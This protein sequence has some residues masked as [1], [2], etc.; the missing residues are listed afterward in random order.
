[1]SRFYRYSPWAAEQYG[2]EDRPEELIVDCPEIALDGTQYA[3][4][5]GD[6]LVVLTSGHT[7]SSGVWLAATL[8][9]AAGATLIGEPTGDI[10]DGI[11]NPVFL[12]LPHSG[13]RVAISS[14]DFHL[15]DHVEMDRASP[16]RPDIYVEA[17]IDDILSGVD[18][19]MAR[20]LEFAT[21]R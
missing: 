1:M 6:N 17:S 8:K 20:A 7:R 13:L 10:P 19:Q 14:A 16:L 15:P 2:Y 3:M 11:G 12:T 21:S 9:Y 18:L 4:D 5:F